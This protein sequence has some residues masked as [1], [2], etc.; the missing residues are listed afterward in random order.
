MVED[1]QVKFKLI[2]DFAVSLCVKGRVTLPV[3]AQHQSP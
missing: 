1:L 2:D 3:T